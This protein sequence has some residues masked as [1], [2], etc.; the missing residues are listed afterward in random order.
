MQGVSY[1]AFVRNNA[2]LWDVDA[3]FTRILVCF[4][5]RLPIPPDRV[6]TRVVERC[7]F[8]LWILSGPS[9][10]GR[11][12]IGDQAPVSARWESRLHFPAL[13]WQLV[14]L[15]DRWG[16]GCRLGILLALPEVVWR[17]P[18]NLKN[19][20]AAVLPPA[21][22]IAESNCPPDY[23]CRLRRPAILSRGKK[24]LRTAMC[25]RNP[26]SVEGLSVARSSSAARLRAGR[27][28][29]RSSLT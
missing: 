24:D 23:V 18:V 22:S 4:T 7:L 13:R 9:K 16:I 19:N 12:L 17:G 1:R 15:S 27:L 3:S 10:T 2:S 28:N 26:D 21:S 5:L 11:D 14:G 8:C 20:A 6:Q 29:M 25:K